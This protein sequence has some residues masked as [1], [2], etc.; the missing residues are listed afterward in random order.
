MLKYEKKFT[1]ALSELKKFDVD[2]FFRILNRNWKKQ[3]IYAKEYV[4]GERKIFPANF[5]FQ[6]GGVLGVAHLGFFKAMETIGVRPVGIAGTS[7]GAIVGMLLAA[8][9]GDRLD[10]EVGDDLLKILWNCPMEQFLD[11]P[12]SSR[13]LI[14][15]A[16]ATK[17]IRLE[18]LAPMLAVTRRLLGVFGVHRGELFEQWLEGILRR[19]FQIRSIGDLEDILVSF[20]NKINPDIRPGSILKIMATALPMIGSRKSSVGVK[21]VLPSDLCALKNKYFNESPAILV[22]MSMSIPLFFE[23]R[24]CDIQKEGWIKLIDSIFDNTMHAKTKESLA[25]ATSVAFIDGGLL[26]N[27][28]IDAFRDEAFGKNRGLQINH[29]SAPTLASFPTLGSTLVSSKPFDSG[30][31][32]GGIKA[33]MSHAAAVVDGMRHVRDRDAIRTSRTTAAASK[34]STLHI[35]P[36]DVGDHNWLNFQL[37]ETDMADLYL[38]GIR[39]AKDFIEMVV[40]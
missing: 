29:R 19:E 28:P 31:R 24:Q 17:S 20:G 36:V 11:G 3:D 15:S 35:C 27:F 38:R 33:L 5:V 16:L 21:F 23:P 26:S 14:K 10:A 6:G 30:G 2:K 12:Y 1:D 32:A 25:E 22:R 8:A 7:A 9:R 13:R 39:S 37:S 40:G 18:M 34:I 4:G